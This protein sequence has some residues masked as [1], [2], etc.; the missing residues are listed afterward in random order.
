MLLDGIVEINSALAI[1]T[2]QRPQVRHF[3]PVVAIFADRNTVKISASH[4]R[5]GWWTVGL[6]AEFLSPKGKRHV[7][8]SLHVDAK[9]PLVSRVCT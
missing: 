9:R 7:G 1:G 5:R 3:E 4:E 8:V 6:I 2:A